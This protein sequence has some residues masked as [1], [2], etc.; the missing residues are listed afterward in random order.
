DHLA[1]RVPERAGAVRV[2]RRGAA[3]FLVRDAGR[4]RLRNLLLGLRRQCPGAR[5]LDPDRS[6]QGREGRVIPGKDRMNRISQAAAGRAPVSLP[7]RVAGGLVLLALFGALLAGCTKKITSIDPAF[8]V[9][10]GRYSTSAVLFSYPNSVLG[11][12]VYDDKDASGGYTIND[13]LYVT[14]DTSVH[15]PNSLYGLIVDSTAASGYQVFRREANGALRR[16]NDFVL[17]PER[18]WLDTGWK[19]YRF[20]DSTRSGYQPP[21]YIGRGVV[22]GGVTTR[23]PLTNFTQLTNPGIAPIYL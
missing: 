16:L 3:R 21:T 12:N 6:R 9:P 11:F 23:S 7:R 1:H 4:S 2:G 17:A 19:A 15:A 5:H 13:T 20:R 14:R 10:E 8:T 18:R 22:G